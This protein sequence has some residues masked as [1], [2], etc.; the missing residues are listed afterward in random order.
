M[1][2]QMVTRYASSSHAL[3]WILLTGNFSR[4]TLAKGKV[5]LDNCGCLRNFNEKWKE[6]RNL[7]TRASHNGIYM[8]IVLRATQT[9][10]QALCTI[11][12]L[13]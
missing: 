9:K 7:S 3:P 2:P 5:T 6:S 4:L 8:I 1:L 11:S 10:C 12:H 13:F